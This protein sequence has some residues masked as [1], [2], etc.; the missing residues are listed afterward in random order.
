MSARQGSHAGG[1]APAVAGPSGDSLG[2]TGTPAQADR[3][4]AT[5]RAELT[6]A[7]CGGSESAFR[8]LYALTAPRLLGYLVCLARDRTSAEE[9]LQ[10][11]FMKLHQSRG[12]YI[13]GADPLPWLLTIAHRTFLDETRRRKRSCVELTRDANVPDVPSGDDTSGEDDAPYSPELISS[14]LAELHRLPE[15]QRDALLLTK[16]Q[17]LSIA[18]AAAILGATRVAIKLRAHRGYVALREVFRSLPARGA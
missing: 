17:G 12:A 4:G 8:E 7:Y 9:I 16:I 18:D 6:T 3:E 11:T 14:V 15:G 10:A 1:A 13:H 5:R 2:D